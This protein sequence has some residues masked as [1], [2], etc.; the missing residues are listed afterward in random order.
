MQLYTLKLSTETERICAVTV[1]N[2]QTSNSFVLVE[3][4]S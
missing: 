2:E 1:I 3:K 4:D